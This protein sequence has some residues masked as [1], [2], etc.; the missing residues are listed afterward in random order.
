MKISQASREWHVPL[1]KFIGHRLKC[2]ACG[3]SFRAFDQ[4]RMY[5][6]CCEPVNNKPMVPWELECRQHKCTAPECDCPADTGGEA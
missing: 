1:S 2:I 4:A 5:C 6:G 3:K